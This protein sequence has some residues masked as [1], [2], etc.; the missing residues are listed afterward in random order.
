MSVGVSQGHCQGHW[1]A[2]EVIHS[3]EAVNLDQPLPRWLPH[4]LSNHCPANCASTP[5]GSTLAGAP[6]KATKLLAGAKMLRWQSCI[7]QIKPNDFN[8]LRAFFQE[9]A[10]PPPLS[11][12]SKIFP[13]F[14]AWLHKKRNHGR[15]GG[16]QAIPPI[17]DFWTFRVHPLKIFW[18]R[19]LLTAVLS[20]PGPGKAA[21]TG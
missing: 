20:D 18:P 19:F 12:L 5:V 2:G 3:Q 9:V 7:E 15:L 14:Y 21:G 13:L 11:L 16:F 6:L 8:L 10:P 4:W 1:A 17:L